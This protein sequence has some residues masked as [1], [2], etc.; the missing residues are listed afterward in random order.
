MHE[1]GHHPLELTDEEKKEIIATL[2]GPFYPI[3]KLRLPVLLRLDEE[4]AGANATYNYKV[5]SVE[6]VLP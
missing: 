3:T 1:H 6:H 4:L 2:D 5:L